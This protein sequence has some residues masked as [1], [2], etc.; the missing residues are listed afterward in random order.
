M[1]KER[2][3]EGRGLVHLYIGDGKGKTSAAFG[4]ALRCR[5]CGGR[6]AIV[7]FLKTVPTGEV[8]FFNQLSDQKLCVYRFESPHGF[9][10]QLDEEQKSALQGEIARAMDFVEQKASGQDCDMLVLDEILGALEDGL[11]DQQRLL[12]ILNGRADGVEIVMTGRYAPQEVIEAAD[13]VSRIMPVK[14][15]YEKGILARRGIEY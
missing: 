7:Q 13:Y 8:E 10:H 6:V 2:L 4:L 12:A 9:F 3:I 5:G 14:H 11:V 1:H 15:P